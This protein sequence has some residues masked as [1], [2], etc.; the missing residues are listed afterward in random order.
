MQGRGVP[1]TGV[2][3]V[4]G[5]GP[6]GSAAAILLA[7]AGREVV[8]VERDLAPGHKVCGEFIS[9]EAVAALAGLGVNLDALGARRIDRVR[10]VR[11]A[12]V[13]EAALPFVAASLTRRALDTAL[14]AR[15]EACGVRLL[16]GRVVRDVRR[17]RLELDGP[18]P[19][20]EARTDEPLEASTVL[21]ATGK[22]DLRGQRRVAPDPGAGSLVGFKTYW[23]LAP[24]Q[25]RA[26]EG[27][28]EVLLFRGAA[29]GGARRRAGA[30]Q[31]FYGG[32]QPV[33]GGWA[34]LCVLVSRERLDS[35]GGRW[36]AVLEGLCAECPHLQARLA[37]AGALLERPLSIAR[38]PYGFVHPGG[39]DGVFRLGD[40]MAVIPSFSGDGI[41]IALHS[42]GLAAQ[43]LLAGGDAGQY[44]RQM[45]AAVA[46]PMRVARVLSVVGRTGVGQAALVTACRAWPGVIR[47]AALGTR[48]G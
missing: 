29:G 22:H 28:V 42:A 31:A 27:H 14:Q 46:R 35:A 5:G 12:R 16:R 7:Q 45:R 34:N 2:I 17:D 11:G 21:L 36:D 3:A 39:E 9:R 19:D 15:A 6:A 20:G 32:L 44:A 4:A 43:V 18:G 41:A 10:V 24:A 40:Q 38:V 13:L 47:A 1:Q 25:A 23:R 8:L 48:V 37:G 30:G 33:E 26:L